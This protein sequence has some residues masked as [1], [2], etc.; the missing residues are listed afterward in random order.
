MLPRA[1]KNAAS[2]LPAWLHFLSHFLRCIDGRSR[3]KWL[4]FG[5]NQQGSADCPLRTANEAGTKHLGRSRVETVVPESPSLSVLRWVWF[6]KRLHFWNVAGQ[7]NFEAGVP[8][9]PELFPFFRPSTT[10]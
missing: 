6:S 4:R 7:S 10:V 3:I 8:L 2:E 9:V 5:E 1:I